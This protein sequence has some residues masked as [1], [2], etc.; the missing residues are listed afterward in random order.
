MP[1]TIKI[2]GSN[3]P[4]PIVI[5]GGAAIVIGGVFYYRKNKE[6]AASKASVDAASSSEIDPATGYPYGSAEDAAALASQ[7]SYQSP[8]PSGYGYTGYAGGSGAVPF[9]SGAPGSF[10]N[11]AEWA[12]FVE[13]Y[14]INN[15][16]ADGPA[17]GNAIGKY[18]SG[19]PL[20]TDAMVSIVQS[21]IAIGGYPPV[22]GPNGHPPG[23]V[24][25]P[26]PTVPPTPTP[27]AKASPITGLKETAKTRTSFTVIWNAT[28]APQGYSY[29]VKQLNG[30]I[31]KLGQTKSHSVNITGMHPGWSYNFSIHGI[32]NG[33][34]N[35]V[36]IPALPK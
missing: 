20:T 15:M 4:K 21:A 23:Y 13:A 30:K 1:D 9:G 32:P 6:D 22:S 36:H 27:T 12:Q 18:I 33:T 3:V 25:V 2:F 8:S 10:T 16:G 11:N 26:T 14:E 5:G 34:G 31:V 19:Q 35:A 29:M 24:T 28:S 7:D 17:V